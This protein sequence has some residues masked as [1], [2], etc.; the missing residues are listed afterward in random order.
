MAVNHSLMKRRNK[1]LLGAGG[2]LL[3][4]LLA[5]WWYVRTLNRAP[6]PD[7]SGR[8]TLA[9]LQQPVEVFRDSLGIPHIYAR[10]EHDLYLTTGY[11]AAQ[12]RLWQMDLLRRVTQGRLSE[13]FGDK[14]LE[15]DILLRKLQI[16]AT[17][18]R[19]WEKLEAPMRQKLEWYAQGVNAWIDQSG[20]KLPPEFKILGYKPEAWQPYE[21]LYLV[22]Y[23]SWTLE[24]GYK[25]E[26]MASE[27]RR[28]L[29]PAYLKDILPHWDENI[30]TVYGDYRPAVRVKDSALEAALAF[31]AGHVPA[32]FNG[33]NNW[34][35]SGAKSLTGKPLFS[36]DMH[37]HLS[38]PGIWWRAHQVVPG[39]LNVT[40]VLIPGEP[41][42]VAGH[43]DSIAWGMTNVMLDGADFYAEKIDTS[44]QAY[45]VD[46]QWKPLRVV[47]EKIRVK[48]RSQ[49]VTVKTYYTH[50]GPILTR[51]GLLD[52]APVSMR[53]IGNE[54]SDEIRALYGFNTARNWAE[55]RRA[56]RGFKAVSQ[57]I[58][59]ADTHG[60]IGLQCTGNIPVRQAPGYLIYPGQTTRY[61]WKGFYPFD[62][63]PYTYDPPRG[64]VCSANNRTVKGGPYISEWFDLPYRY[65]RI[66]E[67]LETK[68][69]LGPADFRRMLNDHYSKKAEL[70]MQR[71]RRELK[72]EDFAGKKYRIAFD[73]LL[74][75][76]L[77]Y[78]KA[79]RA[80]LL[81]D[82][83]MRQLVR[84]LT[85]DEMGD[86]LF[87]AY[88][89]SFLFNKYLTDHLMRT[90]H[91][92]WT[93][94]VRT[95]QKES[96]KDLLRLSLEQAVDSLDA[97]YGGWQK[98]T[99]GQ[100]HHLQLNHPLSKVK[101]LDKL[102]GLSHHLPAPGGIN[103]VNPFTYNL[104]KP[105]DAYL[106]A[107]QKHIYNTADW[108]Q[109]YSILPAGE[110]GLP[111]SPHYADQAETYVNGGLFPDYFSRAKV[112]KA[113]RY[114]LVLLPKA[115]AGQSD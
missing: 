111:A 54:D 55:F 94:N 69:K 37:L 93:D 103:T 99:W 33:S 86:T 101:I 52:V 97:R 71:L 21:S 22:G 19:I 7:Y 72:R 49:P 25:M 91:S 106:G 78:E 104:A 18:R 115:S 63:L 112:E 108:D 88:Y 84:N 100:V 35:V 41:F 79:Y 75:W 102:F 39:K 107:S 81:L 31:L 24:L 51:I 70:V 2:I 1:I 20:D 60:H 59:Y 44:R 32:V 85:A 14:A 5:G 90:G 57:N 28:R 13:I 6:L 73:T 27:I 34:V 15:A 87:K 3:A 30:E 114:H 45:W 17:S 11:L 89:N 29:G 68:E 36:N 16:P 76:N 61:D 65:R 40:G 48:G 56:A 50:R 74:N 98:T 62:S 9:G 23:M 109:S 110:S 96:L 47:N 80:P 10:N 64:Y 8:I 53:W 82:E 113:A 83:T 67:M 58:A 66:R 26:A 42:V 92:V 38:M 46:G 105:Y 43:N 77:R 95:P 12:D 4:L